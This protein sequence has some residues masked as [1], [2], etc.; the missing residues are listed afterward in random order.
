MEKEKLISLQ[1]NFKAEVEALKNL[2]RQVM[3]TKVENAFTMQTIS[4]DST[5]LLMRRHPEE[6]AGTAAVHAAKE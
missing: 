2:Y 4:S 5:S 1:T 6:P 3:P